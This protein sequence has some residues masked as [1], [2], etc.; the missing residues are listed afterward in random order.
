MNGDI[1]QLKLNKANYLF[2]RTPNHLSSVEIGSSILNWMEQTEL[3]FDEFKERLMHKKIDFNN[4]V[5]IINDQDPQ[6]SQ[7]IW[8]ELFKNIFSSIDNEDFEN[9]DA[10][11][12]FGIPI[13]PFTRYFR[14]KLEETISVRVK[15]YSNWN[16][17]LDGLE[18]NLYQELKTVSCKL[19]ISDFSNKKEMI[20]NNSEENLLNTYIRDF[21]KSKIYLTKVFENFPVLTR[22]LTE[23]TD[24]YSK[25]CIL[26]LER[27]ACDYLDINNTM[28]IGKEYPKLKGISL[29]EG[30]THKGGQTVAIFTFDNE[31]KVVYKPRSLD[32]DIQYNSFLEW[33]NNHSTIKHH[34]RK[35]ITIDRETY[36]WQEFIEH[37]ECESLQDIEKYYYRVGI[38][39]GVFHLFGTTD[40]HY[41]NLISSG[42]HPNIIDL[43]TL[44]ANHINGSESFKFPM[45]QLLDSVLKSGLLPTGQLF[46]S[47]I[48]FDLSA[49]TGIPNQKSD[50][51]KGWVLVDD[52]SDQVKFE[53][54]SFITTESKHL[55]FN[56]G[57]LIDPREY[58]EFINRGLKDIYMVFLENKEELTNVLTK[59]FSKCECRTILRPTYI[60]A[61]FLVASY[62][63]KYLK[64]G[65][66]RE[67]LLEMLWNMVKT[68]PKFEGIVDFEIN[69]ILNHDIPF[70][71]FRMNSTSIFSSNGDEIINIFRETS[72][73]RLIMKLQNLNHEDLKRQ[74]QYTELMLES[75]HIATMESSEVE[76]LEYKINI[77]S[78]QTNN[79]HLEKAIEIG[80]YL[81]N[82]AIGNK[83]DGPVTWIGMD[84]N[85]ETNR[86]NLKILDPTLYNG[87]LGISLF[88]AQLGKITGK[89]IYTDY[90]RR[91]TVYVIDIIEEFGNSLPP[92]MYSGL[93]SVP[94]TL[95][96]LG[97]IWDDKFLFDKGSEYLNEI[98]QLDFTSEDVIDFLGGIAGFITYYIELYKLNNNEE[99]LYKINE[100]CTILIQKL[101][102]QEIKIKD[103]TFLT[104]FAHGTSG[105]IYSLSQANKYIPNALVSNW[106]N[107]LIQYE[108]T[109]YNSLQL[110]WAD[111]RDNATDIWNSY[112]WCH[113]APGVLLNRS[114][115]SKNFEKNEVIPVNISDIV[116]SFYTQENFDNRICLCHGAFGNVDIIYSVSENLGNKYMQEHCLNHSNS[117]LQDVEVLGKIEGMK[118][119]GLIGLFTG[120]TGVGYSL[121]RLI[122]RTVPNILT[123][124]LPK[125][126]E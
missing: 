118:K 41:E 36:G 120:I 35:I 75:N 54:V 30:D 78:Y 25:N 11:L 87:V 61:R 18:A 63:P 124:E 93:G 73:N 70:F 55:V 17:V 1:N 60:Y 122:D 6:H 83:S 47:N 57:V 82:H 88:L 98:N 24:R 80:D 53:N 97:E 40:M 112:Y 43:E 126:V 86:L 5:K 8:C 74:L 99:L 115:M 29:G 105:I 44:F 20:G 92:S 14:K 64:D 96:Y 110:N 119:S 34:L 49:I 50:N 125:R 10:S 84:T 48:D 33:V 39:I 4:F 104:G 121:L 109:H 116:E 66:D 100:L 85:P 59:L 95:H 45:D 15:E 114:I 101:Q 51:M 46:R 81:I 117:L 38:L 113:G 65:L 111:L 107:K 7:Q 19:F 76:A 58:I 37:A 56:Q 77:P 72:L 9:M 13:I 16:S 12:G 102:E 21:L 94:Y 22:S 2:E 32:I 28:G 79:I 89:E 68:E 90:A 71:T 106:V 62:H 103:N 91:A 108:D 27:F 3:G 67:K 42:E 26:L 23:I 69:E 31:N 123:L 52:N